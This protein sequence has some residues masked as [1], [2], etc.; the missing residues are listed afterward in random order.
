MPLDAICLTALTKELRETLLGG[1]IDKIHQPARDEVVIA[2]RTQKNGGQRLLLSA[3]PTRLRGRSEEHT[4][5]LQSHSR[6]LVC[7]LLLEKKNTIC[8]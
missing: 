1:R 2:F 8:L 6:K 3:S 5:E 7:R 4:S